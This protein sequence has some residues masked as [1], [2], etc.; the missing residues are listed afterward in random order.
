MHDIKE[1]KLTL[2]DEKFVG[3][4]QAYGCVWRALHAHKRQCPV[5]AP[6]APIT[7]SSAPTSTRSCSLKDRN[8]TE[9]PQHN[10]T[11]DTSLKAKEVNVNA[12]GK[13]EKA[14]ERVTAAASD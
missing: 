11:Q 8:P 7:R 12:E 5:E 2:L 3:S 6:T 10:A 4:R 1:A 9:R 13:T 14:Q